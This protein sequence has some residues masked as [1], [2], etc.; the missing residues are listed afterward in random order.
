M[1]YLSD[2][3]ELLGIDQDL[4][5]QVY[6]KMLHLDMSECTDEQFER[7]VFFAYY[8]VTDEMADKV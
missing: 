1:M 6:M 7:E 2:I 5:S 8:L 4:A 3:M